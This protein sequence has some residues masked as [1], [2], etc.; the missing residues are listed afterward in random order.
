MPSHGQMASLSIASRKGCQRDC[1][2]ERLE[3]H[4]LAALGRQ[5]IIDV[6]EHLLGDKRVENARHVAHWTLRDRSKGGRRE[7]LTDHGRILEQRPFNAVEV[8]EPRRHQRLQRLGHLAVGD[9]ASYDVAGSVRRHKP[10]IEQHP[11]GLHR[12]QGHALGTPANPC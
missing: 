10:P 12:V 6:P 9:I 4:V 2:Q 5:R 11:N 8:I 1:P 3:E 7:R